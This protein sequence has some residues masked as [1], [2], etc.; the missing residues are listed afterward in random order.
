ML[1]KT[2]LFLIT[3]MASTTLFTETASASSFESP[4]LQKIKSTSVITPEESSSVPFAMVG[5]RNYT[6]IFD[7]FA[8]AFPMHLQQGNPTFTFTGIPSTFLTHIGLRK[9][10]GEYYS[11]GG[12]RAQS[13]FG[14]YSATYAFSGIPLGDYKVFLSD[15]S[16]VTS[17][18]DVFISWT[19]WI[20]H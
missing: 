6:L 13:N 14:G 16:G 12:V 5:Y 18:G 10:T 17:Y 4:A 7:G 15:N 8:S 2:T 3:A 9:S 1:K 11:S 20:N 19:G